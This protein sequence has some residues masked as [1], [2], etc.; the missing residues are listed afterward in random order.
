MNDVTPVDAVSAGVQIQRDLTAMERWCWIINQIFPHNVIPRIRVTGDIHEGAL[1]AALD[2]LQQENWLLRTAIAAES[3]GTNPRFL[4]IPGRSIPVRKVIVASHD[5]TA[6]EREVNDVE[7]REFIDWKSGPL[8]RMVHMSSE[9]SAK[10]EQWHDIILTVSHIIADGTTAFMLLRR[11]VELTHQ[12]QI[13]DRPTPSPSR[14]LDRKSG[15]DNWLPRTHL[16]LWG[17]ARERLFKTVNQAIS[18]FRPPSRMV[19]DRPEEISVRETGFIS[20]QIRSEPL[21][22]LY[23]RCREEGVTVHS[24]L[25]GA[26]AV[27][28]GRVLSPAAKIWLNISSPVNC[29]ADMVPAIAPSVVGCYA[30][31]VSAMV[32]VGDQRSMWDAARQ[33]NR[34]VKIR[35]RAGEHLNRLFVMNRTCPQSL[36]DSE[37]AVSHVI[38]NGPGSICVS[39]M[40]EF[41]FPDAIGDWTL[42]GAQFVGAPSVHVTL[43]L[44]TNI[45][46][47][48]LQCNL[49]HVYNVISAVHAKELIDD[50]IAML[51]ESV[52]GGVGSRR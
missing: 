49:S 50:A 21:E 6:W 25:A 15:S 31:S 41:T 24:A 27:A 33:I 22:L 29:R 42:D 40:K 8:L 52:M 51:E 26:L 45:S 2:H 12:F 34:E 36:K 1:R 20:R 47:G 16:G 44:T 39:S 17:S 46:H 3:D 30:A 23:V 43:L 9:G 38:R 11:L 18:R 28:T 37:R 4:E 35:R 19:I 14:D 48:V 7:L 5:S 32:R 10:G 13:G